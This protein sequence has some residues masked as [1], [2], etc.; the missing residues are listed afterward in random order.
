VI[1]NRLRG[2]RRPDVD[3][4][5][6]QMVEKGLVSKK[7]VSAKNGHKTTLYSLNG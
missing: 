3:K 1:Y 6:A 7:D 4:T 5:L 2:H